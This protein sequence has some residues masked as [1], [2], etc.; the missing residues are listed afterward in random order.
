MNGREV[1][2]L[3][4]MGEGRHGAIRDVV[5]HVV[6]R[7]DMN[8]QDVRYAQLTSKEG[9]NVVMVESGLGSVTSVTLWQNVKDGRITIQYG[10]EK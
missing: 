7:L 2:C 6:A 1:G 8:K 3:T 10:S 9:L 5:A 4:G